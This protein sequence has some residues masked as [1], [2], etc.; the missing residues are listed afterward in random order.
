[1]PVFYL[2]FG[3]FFAWVWDMGMNSPLTW[4]AILLWPVV[5]AVKVA[6]FMTLWVFIPVTV[7]LLL[8]WMFTRFDRSLREL[9]IRARWKAWVTHIRNGP[10]APPSPSA[11]VVDP[12]L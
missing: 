3:L 4:I 7:V 10:Q 5:L 12:G 6:V 11:A 8:I 2:V 1:M 9:N